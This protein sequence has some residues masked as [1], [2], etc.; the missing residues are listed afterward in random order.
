M[1]GEQNASAATR[2]RG[3][4]NMPVKL[5]TVASKVRERK[6]LIEYML[7]CALRNSWRSKEIVQDSLR[8]AGLE[9]SYL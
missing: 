2:P 8:K 3:H 1:C 7:K 6:L 9:A 4:S 5:G